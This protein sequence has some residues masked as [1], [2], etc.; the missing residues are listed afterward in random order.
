M[1]AVC[2]LKLLLN[3]KTLNYYYRCLLAFILLFSIYSDS[4][5]QVVLDGNKCPG[6]WGI[7]AAVDKD[8]K[9]VPGSSNLSRFW[10]NLQGTGIN[11]AF[12]RKVNLNGSAAFSIYLNTD[13]DSTTGYTT[14]A[15]AEIALFMNINA[16]T[17]AQKVVY[18]WDDQNSVFVASSV[19][20]HVELGD[21]TCNGPSQNFF[22]CGVSAADIL[23][24]CNMDS[25]GS[26]TLTYAA[27]HAGQ[28]FQSHLVDTMRVGA[29]FF[30]NSKPLA[31]IGPDDIKVCSG[32]TVT[33]DATQ[34]LA[35][36]TGSTS[37]GYITK[38]EWDID[39]NGTFK[40]DTITP[41]LDLTYIELNDS[42]VYYFALVVTDTFGCT[43][44]LR[45]IK[46]TVYKLPEL[47]IDIYADTAQW[48]RDWLWHYNTT[49]S[50]DY[51][52]DPVSTIQW[53]LPDG[54][55]A[56]GDSIEHYYNPCLWS[57]PN[58]DDVKAI[59][60]D[61]NGCRDTAYD[62]SYLG[63]EVRSWEAVRRENTI[64]FTWEIS[65]EKVV[66][67]FEIERS[68]NLENFE[69]IGEIKANAYLNKN[70][71]Y[72][73]TASD[74]KLLEQ[75]YRL[76]ILYED[77]TVHYL[78]VLVL[79]KLIDEVYKVYPNPTNGQLNLEFNSDIGKYE[80]F[81]IL[82]KIHL[83]GTFEFNKTLALDG[84][85]NGTYYVHVR[86][87]DLSVRKKIILRR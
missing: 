39:Y 86:S 27:S 7:A 64:E 60:I 8:F 55:I 31:R 57:L 11:F 2:S 71:V 75:Y 84:L 66:D 26:I 45:D 16:G 20:M 32:E 13:N 21:S 50:I 76:K 3:M 58:F 25:T 6:E 43:D 78:N 61:R 63:L 44:T 59:A 67:K 53:E 68:Q 74:A 87:E 62:R 81:D 47:I 28:V 82:G 41:S 49:F 17:I 9:K 15:G 40:T 30:I 69:A 80:V 79:P 33:L 24:V 23:D 22:E 77:E 37:T 29:H 12:T 54:T 5:A 1:H 18:L 85:Q 10:Y 48:C 38:Y 14:L 52:G 35:N 42:T 36:G 56:L 73:F 46:L 83:S 19:V 65:T 70:A 51:R 4:F 72:S 34:S